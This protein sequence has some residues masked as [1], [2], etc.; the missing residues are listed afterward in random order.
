MSHTEGTLVTL[1]VSWDVAPNES[2]SVFTA[3]YL[4]NHLGSRRVATFLEFL[5]SLPGP[6]GQARPAA[7]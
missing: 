2:S 3:R 7:Q 1:L 4:R 6:T 5:S